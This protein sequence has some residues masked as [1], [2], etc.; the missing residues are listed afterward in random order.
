MSKQER[1]LF[2]V[3]PFRYW[4]PETE[5]YQALI[6]Q[7]AVK[8]LLWG[9]KTDPQVRILSD[10]QITFD[11]V[12]LGKYQTYLLNNGYTHDAVLGH[13]RC[14][15]APIVAK[16]TERRGRFTYSEGKAEETA[17]LPTP[18]SVSLGGNVTALFKGK[19]F[20]EWF[21]E[22]STLHISFEIPGRT[23]VSDFDRNAQNLVVVKN[24]VVEFSDSPAGKSFAAACRGKRFR[25]EQPS[26]FGFE[27]GPRPSRAE[28]CE[29]GSR[30]A[31]KMFFLYDF[32]WS[33]D[34][35]EDDYFFFLVRDTQSEVGVG[36][37][38]RYNKGFSYPSSYPIASEKWAAAT[39]AYLE[40]EVYP[41]TRSD[42]ERATVNAV[43]NELFVPGEA[44]DVGG[45]SG[46]LGSGSYYVYGQQQTF[47]SL[48]VE[49]SKLDDVRIGTWSVLQGVAEIVWA[50]FKPHDLRPLAQAQLSS[51]KLSR[52]ER[53]RLESGLREMDRAPD[54]MVGVVR[55]S[56]PQ[57][58]P[59]DALDRIDVRAFGLPGGVSID[60]EVMFDDGANSVT[61]KQANR[62]VNRMQS[63]D[64][65]FAVENRSEGTESFELTVGSA[66]THCVLAE[67]TS[68]GVVQFYIATKANTLPVT[69][70]IETDDALIH[71]QEGYTLVKGGTFRGIEQWSA[72]IAAA[73]D[74]PS[75]DSIVQKD[76][77][78]NSF[79]MSSVD[80]KRY[81]IRRYYQ[82]GFLAW[83]LLSDE[84]RDYVALLSKGSEFGSDVRDSFNMLA[85]ANLGSY[86]LDRQI[87]F[88]A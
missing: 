65:F 38:L 22:M 68:D 1:D 48:R 63:S 51:K 64:F 82:N 88:G 53:A 9:D 7:N 74:V 70:E 13:I 5:S 83:H 16:L 59:I 18:I 35:S 69:N 28:L 37:E 42:S 39:L 44:A 62:K 20:K 4:D 15:N 27:Q 76:A 19:P 49:F 79:S 12:K 66:K 33:V 29:K 25:I 56:R 45:S 85:S 23:G 46:S 72:V 43:I 26:F 60:D 54:T 67:R 75:L 3:V 86:T 52:E 17:A 2:N 71:L 50:K 78:G 41:N 14:L 47:R 61:W 6:D 40:R 24:G 84:D 10:S 34:G 8:V 31:D 77:D 55:Y 32:K 11:E 80:L 57:R 58:L 87:A 30:M 73:L 36:T 81:D 21:P